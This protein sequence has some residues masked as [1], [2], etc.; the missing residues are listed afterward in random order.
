MLQICYCLEK[1]H[2]LSC[3]LVILKKLYLIKI[4]F[5]TSCD[6][7][8]SI[9]GEK[10]QIRKADVVSQYFLIEKKDIDDNLATFVCHLIVCCD[11]YYRISS[12]IRQSFFLPKQ[13][14]RSR[15]VLSCK[16]DLDLWDCLGTVN[17]VL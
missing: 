9:P 11:M 8:I 3:R 16:T 6:I 4:L 2:V 7:Y 14:Q 12:V 15:S 1:L 17:F 5:N 13:S 10:Q